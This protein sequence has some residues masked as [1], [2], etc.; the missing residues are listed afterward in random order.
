M[1]I[2]VYVYVQ[3]IAL[4]PG[5]EIRELYAKV[6]FAIDFKIYMFNILNREEVANGG[7]PKLQEIGPYVF[8]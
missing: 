7:K 5:S 4:K 2:R 1:C 3:A 8:E 6:P